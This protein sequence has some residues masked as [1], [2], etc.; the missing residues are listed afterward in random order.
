MNENISV[1]LCVLSTCEGQ[2]FILF[3]FLSCFPPGFFFFF[4]VKSLNL[5]PPLLVWTGWASPRG[6]PVFQHWNQ[7]CMP[8][9]PAYLHGCQHGS[10]SW[11]EPAPQF[12]VTVIVCSCWLLP[13][14]EV[15]CNA[16]ALLDST[17][18][19]AF[20][21]LALVLEPHS[22]RGNCISFYLLLPHPE[23][24]HGRCCVTSLVFYRLLVREAEHLRQRL[25]AV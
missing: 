8:L 25:K 15:I 13:A 14:I 21:A 11:T 22:A 9:H 16:D 18:T 20:V 3:V 5:E 10:T 24:K 19:V 17:G 7:R 6:L 23:A 12:C 1:C 4:E 2:R